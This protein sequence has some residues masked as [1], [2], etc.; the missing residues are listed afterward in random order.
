MKDHKMLIRVPVE[1]HRQV[2]AEAALLGMSMSKLVITAVNEYLE[3]VKEAK[4]DG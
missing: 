4:K 2:K 3:K 1:W